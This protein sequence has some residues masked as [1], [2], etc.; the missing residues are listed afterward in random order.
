MS[1][2]AARAV[3]RTFALMIALTLAHAS[4]AFSQAQAVVITANGSEQGIVLGSNASLHLAMTATAGLS[5]FASPANVYFGL[6]I[7]APATSPNTYYFD[8]NH[9][10]S[11]NPVP[12]YTGPLS[13]PASMTL[14][15]IANVSQLALTNGA[16]YAWFV[17]VDNGNVNDVVGTAILVSVGPTITGLS[18]TSGLPG[19]SVVISGSNFGA[20]QGSNSIVMFNNVLATVSSWSNTSITAAVP[21]AATSGGVVVVADSV[22]S[23]PVAFQGTPAVA[24][25][26]TDPFPDT[27]FNHP[28]AVLLQATASATNGSI[29]KV[30]FKAGTTLLGTDTSSPYQV[31]WSNPAAGDYSLTAVATD[32]NG[33]THASSAVSIHIS[34]TGDTLGTLAA[35]VASL[36]TGTYGPN[37][38]L[39]LVAAQ[40]TTIR[41]T[42][43]GSIPTS[44]STIYS[45]PIALSQ[46]ITVKA[47]AFQQNWTSS[48]V[49][50]HTYTVDSV[51]PVI[52]SKL[53]PVPT[54]GW[55]NSPVTAS[56]TCTDNLS[57][58]GTCPSPVVFSNEGANQQVTVTA[59]DVVGNQR[60]IVVTVNVDRTPPSVT[61]SAPV[62][63]ASVMTDSVN[64]SGSMNDSLSGLQSATCNGVTA[65]ISSGGLNCTVPLQL[66]LNAIVV[67]A[68]DT[69]GNN[70]SVSVPVTRT[71]DPTFLAVV[72]STRTLA[73]GETVMLSVSDDFGPSASGIVWSTDTA[74]VATVDE[75]GTLTAVGAGHATIAASADGLSA[76]MAVT[77][78]SAASLPVGTTRWVINA[79]AG[80]DVTSTVAVTGPG[81][82]SLV[83]IE[84][85]WSD[86]A[87]GWGSYIN[88]AVRGFTIDG[89][90][91]VSVNPGLAPAET[92]V[93]TIGDV[94]GGILLLV[95]KDPTSIAE[96]NMQHSLGIPM[97]LVRVGLTAADPGWRYTI[98]RADS[99]SLF[100]NGLSQAPDGTIFVVTPTRTIVGIDGRSGQQ[101]FQIA[102]PPSYSRA[103]YIGW[104][105][106]AGTGVACPQYNQDVE[107]SWEF[108]TVRTDAT[109][110][111]NAVVAVE[112]STTTYGNIYPD[113]TSQY[114]GF[115]LVG[116]QRTVQIQLYRVSSSG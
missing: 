110:R 100:A 43:D 28:A 14:L 85:L 15:D 61:V 44:A 106:G 90:P 79:P 62:V 113:C 20:T 87:D 81:A 38:V 93:Q 7:V 95:K 86:G 35:P 42:T 70:T 6:V 30:D 47:Q 41:Y 58:V 112:D 89:Q 16:I 99:P 52:T 2:P 55:N 31:S 116:F 32:N 17:L 54:A 98:G 69:A 13:N 49:I 23:S 48:P 91:T 19:G 33:L 56:F 68:L 22:S 36:S 103:R 82:T 83:K 104:N 45:S 102:P 115:V 53:T 57:G 108:W 11:V 63:G 101:R 66:G 26:L 12:F 65:T 24:T 8:H 84:Q 111:A 3:T 1:A 46:T 96:L 71:G 29:S 50:S 88:T 74:S 73:V 114:G 39:S 27:T 78:L 80:Y 10:P 67:Q 105:G 64:V 97:A 51:P 77:V 59:T 40:G 21:A 9:V 5:G 75:N 76:P 94:N 92:V 18:P 60:T 72:P 109:G 4:S 34:A 107:A 25:Q 37:R